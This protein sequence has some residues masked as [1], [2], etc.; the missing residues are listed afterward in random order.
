VTSSRRDRRGLDHVLTIL[1]LVLAFLA[2]SFLARNS[3]FWFHL[4]TGR[5]LA[6]GQFSFGTD[7]FAYTTEQVY[8]VCHSWLFD[9]VMYGLYNLI[10]GA[11]LV[12]LKAVLATALAGLLLSVRRPAGAAWLPAVC[13]TLAILVLS[14][15]LL[16]QPACISYLLLGLTFW[17]L[18]QPHREAGA[19]RR[20]SYSLL[21]L[22]VF[23]IWVNVDEWFVLGPVLVAL[24]WLG[25]RLGGVRQTP[26]WLVPAGLAVCLLNPHTYHAFTLPAELSPVLWTSGLRQDLRFQT[27][28]ASPWQAEY[29]RAA[30]RLNAAALGYFILTA[31][32]LVSFLFHRPALRDWRLLVW[33]PFAAL[34]AWHYHAIPFFAVVAA[35]ITVLNWQDYLAGR[36]E[37][38]TRRTTLSSLVASVSVCLALLALICFT[39][40]GRLSGYDRE[41]RHVAWGL[42]TEPSLQRAAETLDLWRQR[43]L[44]PADKRVFAVSVEAAQYSAWFCPGE[45]QFFD[46]RYP[47][48]AGTAADYET[49]CR[50]L[51]PELVPTQSREAAASPSSRPGTKEPMTDWREVLR[52]HKV[53]AL[54]YYE[55]DPQRLFAVLHR[56]AADPNHWTLLAVA[57]QALLIGW[58]DDQP[59][60]FESLAFDPERL[61]FGPQDDRARQQAPAAPEQGPERLPPGRTFWDRLAGPAAPP[62]WES[63]AAAMYLHYFND[64]EIAQ[65]QS[66]WQSSLL[67][68]AAS[69]TGLPAQTFGLTQAVFQLMSAGDLFFPQDPESRFL[70]REQLGPFFSALVERSPAL[71]LLAVRAARRAVAA[72]PQDANAWLRLG[73]AYLL[74][75]NA[76]CERSH[77]GLLPPLAQLR[78]VQIVTALEQ[79]VRLDPDLEAAHH[80]LAFLYGGR[81]YLDQALEHRRQEARLSHR[82]GPHPGESAEETAYRLELIDKDFAKLAEMVE[83]RRKTYASGS[84]T[85]QGDRVKQ[86]NLALKLGLARQ[87]VDEILLPTAANVLGPDGIRLQLDL[88]LALGRVEEVRPIL[89][90]KGLRASKHGLG[91]YEL[92]P[93]GNRGGGSLYAMPYHWPAYE[94]LHMLEAASVGDYVQARGDLRAARAAQHAE[95]DQLRQAVGGIERQSWAMLP[96]VLS[97]PPLFL[98]AF[99][100]REVV[101]ALELKMVREAQERALRAQQADL[102]V[103][104]GLLA[105]EQGEPDEARLAFAQAQELC[106]GPPETA[107]PFAGRSIAIS[108]LGN[109]NAKERKDARKP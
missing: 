23:A 8:W 41:E 43:G 48:Y 54:I 49:V 96:G 100:A 51:L 95:H 15:R 55:R 78:H 57:G 28:F 16:L 81:N 80:D 4:A 50:A 1:V 12:V 5:L 21:L 3:D 17:L 34:A 26:G 32:G 18:W 13:T 91:Y 62:S 44:L 85:L 99:L 106:A 38:E 9:L 36:A 68:Y 101:P 103:L 22:V 10:G 2:A 27:L 61:V 11:G 52:K 90:E 56:V 35:P 72:N 42:Q 92:A 40:L 104:E 108:Y 39:W 107:A 71:P 88:L 14:P 33:L 59:G 67:G 93:P 46:Y 69:L 84:R 66:Q 58:N 64:S 109:L 24:F 30:G 53:G 79:A 94:W 102:C 74:L 6:Q 37:K 70:M 82:A 47:L 86:A 97:G 98:P 89:N 63:A 77:E 45:K 76:T 83:D 105:L 60:A 31:L 19:A 65:R 75:R 20:R 7:P 25:E 73:Q 29:F 87:A